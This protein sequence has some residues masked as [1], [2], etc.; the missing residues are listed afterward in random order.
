MKEFFPY[1]EFKRIGFFTKEMKGNYEAQAKKVC[2]FFGFKTVYEYGAMEI[3][4]HV[5]YGQNE[6][7]LV[8]NSGGKLQEEPFITCITNI[9]V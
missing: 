1:R 6:R 8:I 2:D 7:P 5:S 9:Y 3:R 4:C